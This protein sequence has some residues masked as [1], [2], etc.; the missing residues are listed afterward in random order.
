MDELHPDTIR[1]KIL[2]ALYRIHNKA[3]GRDSQLTGI[4]NLSQEVKTDLPQIKETLI[5]SN[6]T[7]LVQNG[8]IEEV[9][10]ENYFAKK[11]FGGTKPSYKYRLSREGLAYFEHGSKFDNSSVFA[12][13]GD[14][15]G[16]GNNR[17]V[18]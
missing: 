2:E 9:P 12:G 11:Q 17:L 3:R 7:Y 10:I 16:S 4:R 6:V 5:A 18:P 13:I 14:I 1:E 15:S 8:F